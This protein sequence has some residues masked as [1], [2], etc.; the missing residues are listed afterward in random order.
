M[1]HTF[2]FAGFYST[3]HQSDKKYGNIE[4]ER[5]V[6]VI[7]VDFIIHDEAHPFCDDPDCPCHG[8]PETFKL[9]DRPYKDGLLTSQ[10]AERLFL[11][12]QV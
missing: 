3:W 9:V 5:C 2:N 6:P 1:S 7:L 4:P 11:G 12:R 10:E 8:D